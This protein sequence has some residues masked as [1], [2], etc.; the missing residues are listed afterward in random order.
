MQVEVVLSRW[1]EVTYERVLG[2]LSVIAD[3]V[4]WAGSNSI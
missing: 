1:V 2:H 4:G 3:R